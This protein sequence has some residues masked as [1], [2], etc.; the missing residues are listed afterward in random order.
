MAAFSHLERP[1]TSSL[2]PSSYV[3]NNT[4][5]GAQTLGVS[6]SSPVTYSLTPQ[7]GGTQ[8]TSAV[9]IAAIDQAFADWAAVADIQ[10]TKLTTGNDANI[11][12][13][14]EP[15]ANSDGV[16]GT[17]A[18]AYRTFTNTGGPGTIEALTAAEIEFDVADMATANSEFFYLVALHEIGHTLGL[19]HIDDPTQV[20]Y[21]FYNQSL[22]GLGAGDIAGLQAIYGAT[23]ASGS[24]YGFGAASNDNFDTRSS[25]TDTQ[26][27]GLAGADTL[28]TGTGADTLSGGIGN[29]SLASGSGR[30]LVF[31]NFGDDTLLGQAGEDNLLSLEGDNQFDGGANNDVLRGGIG[32]DTLWGGSGNDAIFGDENIGSNL[33]FGDDILLGEAGNDLLEGGLGRDMFV[34]APNEGFDQ[35]GKISFNASSGFSIA[36]GAADFTPGEDWFDVRGFGFSN[37]GQ[38]LASLSSGTNGA[39]FSSSG[40]TVVL[41]GVAVADLSIDD[42]VWV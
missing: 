33:W 30:D 37:A 39:V 7:F 26:L 17:L 6:P 13:Y 41:I 5:W 23:A 31:D 29:D 36:S 14:F 1:K 42:F 21:D 11:D 38:V 24:G 4:K 15:S 40:T 8:I 10:F 34:F 3:L 35:I 12:L 22:T 9:H 19:D 25:S 20:M 27:F 2:A 18:V 32:D 28:I 16:N